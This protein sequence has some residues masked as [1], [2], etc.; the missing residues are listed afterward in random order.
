MARGYMGRVLWVDLSRQEIREEGLN[1][2]LLQAF[3]GGYGLGARVLFSSQK[4]GVDALADE[5]VL[6]FLTGPL[7]GTAAIGGSR[8]TVVG[9]SPL[10]GG[11]GDANSGG[12]F[13]PYLKFAGYD[14]VFF[15]GISDKPVYLFISEGKSELRDATYLWGKDCYETEDILKFQWGKDTRVACIGP[16][17]EKVSLIAAVM[18]DRGRAAG[19]SGLGAVMGSKKLKAILVNGKTHVPVADAKA[20]GDLRRKYLPQLGGT[21]DWLSEHGT[22]FVAQGSA[23]SGDS[24]VKNWGGIGVVDF[25]DAASFSATGIT[26]RRVKK[27][28]CYRCPIACGAHMMAGNGDYIYEEGCHRP[29]YET[30]ALFGSNCLNNNIESII[31]ANDLCNRYG[32]DTISAGSVLAF[33][34]ECYEKGI[35]TASDTD[36]I[37]MTWGNH[38]SMIA[39]LEKLANREGFGDLI[40]DG[41]KIGAERIGRGADEFAMHIHGQELPGHDPKLDYHWGLSYLLDPTPAR[42]TQNAE[43]FQPLTKVI[44]E[45]RQLNPDAGAACEAG[46]MLHHVVNSS[47][48]CAFVYSCFPRADILAEFLR[49]VT[50][51]DYDIENLTTTGERILNIRQAFAAREGLN[52][53]LFQAPG[54]LLGHP[55][56]VE[57][58]HAGI[59]I[60]EQYWF[61]DYF[62]TVGWDLATGKPN[63]EK[64]IELGLGNIADELWQ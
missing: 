6:G 34:M 63:R 59:S 64:L 5:A 35:V 4:A 39:M 57:G 15:V 9:K 31:K 61:R 14:A 45:D 58:P 43:V 56:S 18:N 1:E 60:D 33:V 27:Y 40:A 19:R 28:G 36:G 16:S 50:G 8:Y 11:W 22:A 29:E 44:K 7:T 55:P 24:P 46:S 41:V 49:A 25:P 17:G 62:A 42:H 52:Q 23:H 3:I 37:E 13:G 51:W 38:R 20:V 53:A 12:D 2:D 32:I 21:I 54:R 47:G 48:L 10:T 30:L 26:A